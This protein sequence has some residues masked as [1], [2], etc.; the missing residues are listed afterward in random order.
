M[1]GTG[2]AGGI[3]PMSLP[4]QHMWILTFRA[5]QNL[6]RGGSDDGKENGRRKVIFFDEAHKLPSLIQSTDTMKYLLDSM[7]VLTKQDRLCH[8]I[9]ATSDPFYQTWLGQ[10]NV[11]Q[12]CRI[13]TVGDCTK[14][15]TR[16]FF[17]DNYSIVELWRNSAR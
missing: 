15:E 10:L 9:H 7:L 4:K 14:A 16:A 8:V 17:R 12:H 11:M 6:G 2:A 5:H 3:I 1:A 13:I